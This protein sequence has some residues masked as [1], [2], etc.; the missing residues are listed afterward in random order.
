MKRIIDRLKQIPRYGW[1]IAVVLFLLDT[2]S[3]Y[4]G[5]LFSRLLGTISWQIA[6]KIPFIDDRIPFIAILVIPYLLSYPIWVLGSAI[7]SLTEKK[8]YVD[9]IISMSLAYFIGFLFFFLMPTYMDRLTEGVLQ[10]AERPGF[11][12]YCLHLTYYND[13][14]RYGFNLFPSFHCMISVFCYLGVRKRKEISKGTRIY[15]LVMAIL[16]C[17]STVC[18]KQHYF[19]DVVGGVLVAIICFAVVKKSNISL[20]FIK[21]KL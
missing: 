21:A 10:R 1:I 11:L 4:F 12:G 16:I 9:Y 8:N 6:P 19:I 20:R 3:Y 15:T 5:T 7:V 13:G 2:T 17:L 14:G 18:I